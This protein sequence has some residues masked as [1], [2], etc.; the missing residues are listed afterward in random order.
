MSLAL[1]RSSILCICGSSKLRWREDVDASK[2][3][4]VEE[5]RLLDGLIYFR[6]YLFVF[7][8]YLSFVIL[9]HFMF[10]YII[11]LLIDLNNTKRLFEDKVI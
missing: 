9:P 5:G 8:L 1:L 11:I 4:V 3:V 6:H 2:G 10:V 7:Q